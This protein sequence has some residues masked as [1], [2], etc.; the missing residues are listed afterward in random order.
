MGY[1]TD[2]KLTELLKHKDQNNGQ[3]TSTMPAAVHIEPMSLM[4]SQMS[5]VNHSK[6]C[7]DIL[8]HPEKNFSPYNAYLYDES[9][10]SVMARRT[11]EK[12]KDIVL[13]TDS[14]HAS[15]SYGTDIESL[16]EYMGFTGTVYI[17]ATG[18][19][20]NNIHSYQAETGLS[21]RYYTPAL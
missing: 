17:T 12:H 13:V 21:G 3:K 10:E 20:G 16:S 15:S 6:I 9:A 1:F 7:K 4:W 5:I 18:N 8:G 2:K 11:L 14:S 19:H